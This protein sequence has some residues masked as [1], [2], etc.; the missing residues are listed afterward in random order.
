MSNLSGN[1]GQVRRRRVGNDRI[2][3]GVEIRPAR[4]PIIRVARHLDILAGI[5]LDKFERAGADRV[6]AQLLGR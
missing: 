3:D 5:E 4:L 1:K 2:L 6:L